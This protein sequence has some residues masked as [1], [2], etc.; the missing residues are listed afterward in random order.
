MEQS[1]KI[2]LYSLQYL[3]AVAAAC[4]VLAHASTTL[5]DMQHTPFLFHAG[6][7]GVDLFFVISGFVMF[8]TTAGKPTT[9][10]NFLLRR[11][12]RIEPIYLILTTFA[13]AL[14][15]LAPKL[16]NLFSPSPLNYVRSILFIPYFN[17]I[18]RDIRPEVQQGW[19]LNY[20]MFFYLLFAC[21]LW[22]KREYRVW[23]C[24]GLL[25]VLA[26]IGFSITPG[27]LYAKTYTSP[28][29][30]EFA[31]GILIGYTLVCRELALPKL[32][33]GFALAG[34]A[35]LFCAWRFGFSERALFAGL[36]AAAVVTL[37]ILLERRGRMGH[38]PLF[39]LVGDASYS[40]YLVHTFVLSALKRVFMRFYNV[41]PQRTELVFLACGLVAATI[42]AILFYRIVEL[43]ITTRLQVLT[44]S[45]RPKIESRKSGVGSQE[46]ETTQSA[47]TV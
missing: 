27:N 42:V 14:A 22:L 44:G 15:V 1:S 7:Y 34:A 5:A 13:F 26:A 32:A 36:P 20:E 39:L 41:N 18:Y 16:S 19:T 46:P 11:I 40:L 37:A 31:F 30:I 3:R 38:W 4:V 23:V 33:T 28:I 29:I 10:G 43:P 17:P 45:R 6:V 9:P 12:I 47:P 35:A 21:C 24:I 2:K 8:Y 25:V